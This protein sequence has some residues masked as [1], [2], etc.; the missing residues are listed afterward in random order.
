MLKSDWPLEYFDLLA[1]VDSSLIEIF[2][3]NEL[4]DDSGQ[5]CA[6]CVHIK[7]EGLKLLRDRSRVVHRQITVEGKKIDLRNGRAHL[8]LAPPLENLVS[9]VPIWIGELQRERE[10][11]TWRA[12]RLQLERLLIYRGHELPLELKDRL[13]SVLNECT[14]PN[15]DG[16]MPPNVDEGTE[17][18]QREITHFGEERSSPEEGCMGD[19]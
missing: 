16:S 11:R 6:T 18:R 14:Q 7:P 8:I 3:N 1:K 10:P 12:I 17:D 5:P 19:L 15:T 2:P 13:V 9:I 4:R